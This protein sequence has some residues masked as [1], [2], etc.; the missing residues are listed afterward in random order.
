VRDENSIVLNRQ[1]ETNKN[2]MFFVCK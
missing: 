1:N 2:A